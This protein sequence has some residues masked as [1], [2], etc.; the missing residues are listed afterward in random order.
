MK[1]K[2]NNNMKRFFLYLY[3]AL[4]L[5]AVQSC[6]LTLD[7][8]DSVNSGV[9]FSSLDNVDFVLNGT[10]SYIWETA[11]T[12]AS[13]GWSTLL[14][15]NDYM[16][17]D[18]VEIGKY[19]YS[20]VYKYNNMAMGTSTQVV[21]IWRLSYK[22]IDNMNNII[23]KIDHVEGDDAKR[24][25]IK[26]QAYAL[27]GYMYL[28][29]ATFYA[30]A[31]QVSADQLCVPI[32]I[33]PT[34]PDTEGK[35]RS[36]QREVFKRAE[37][38]LLD[39]YKLLTESA[40]TYTRGEKYK[41]D[42]NVIAGLLA[43]LYLQTGEWE[44]AVSY[45]AQ[46]HAGYSWMTQND[47]HD[48]FNDLNNAEWIWGQGSSTDQTIS[49]YTF[50]YKDVVSGSSGY[51]SMMADPHFKKLFDEND[52]RYKLFEWENN[53]SK[54][55]LMYKK[56]LY[57][58]NGT[59]DNVLMRKAEMVLIEAEASVEA[60]DRSTA[61]ARLNELRQARGADTPDLSG[62]TGD[63]LIEEIL[64]ERRKELFGEG[65]ALYDIKRR[66]KSVVRLEYP[67]SDADPEKD[68]NGNTIHGHTTTTLPNGQ[69]FTPNSPYY[70]FAVP[71]TEIT[72]N[73][74]W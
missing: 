70:I 74:N 50:N 52:T 24:A 39:A 16:G 53:R 34:T 20:D 55:N 30:D 8:T 32:Y 60:K 45:A 59:A 1:Q 63:Q 33:E 35:K 26:A 47:Y 2:I 22:A 12:W 64:I 13:P 36:T 27:R 7:P 57:K 43:R 14:L 69:P 15:V 19:G 66:Q 44:D 42:T 41:I 73:H 38:D 54:G 31:F 40:P 65:F 21:L 37:D 9:V 46:A 48:G 10:W 67:A 28:N 58:S 68:V 18:V 71:A 49:S 51:Y 3:I 17:S 72:N 29:L 5:P 61:I 4:L 25:R 23:T 6:D 56:F 62:L 11:N